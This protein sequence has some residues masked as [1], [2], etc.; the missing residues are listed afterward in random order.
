ML[1]FVFTPQGLKGK[2]GTKGRSRLRSKDSYIVTV[3]ANTYAKMLDDS[4]EILKNLRKMVLDCRNRQ[5]A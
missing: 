5:S 3:P 2:P 4:Y 1:L